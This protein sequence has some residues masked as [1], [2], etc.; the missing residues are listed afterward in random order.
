MKMSN[1]HK[2]GCFHNESTFDP[3]SAA[4]RSGK[5]HRC[6]SPSSGV[7]E[8]LHHYLEESK[9]NMERLGFGVMESPLYVITPN[10]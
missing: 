7:G 4:T 8:S 6:G 10:A 1:I 5:Y 2:K 9:R 3:L